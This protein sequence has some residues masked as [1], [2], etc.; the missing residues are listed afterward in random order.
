MKSLFESLWYHGSATDRRHHV[1]R[2][3]P[4]LRLVGSGHLL[5]SVYARASIN[6]L[7]PI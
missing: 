1:L 2:S 6:Q 7:S 3:H 4:L 5:Q